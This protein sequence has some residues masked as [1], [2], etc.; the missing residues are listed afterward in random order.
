MMFNL[1]EEE[2]MIQETAHD[3]AES[4]LR[5]RAEE[6]DRKESFPRENF[7][8]LSEL[9]FMGI[10]V[11][12][13]YGGS[14]L[15]DFAL[16][17]V[18]EEINR[19]CA[20]TGVTL[21]VHNSLVC[22][23]ITQFGTEEQKKHYLPKL[24]SGELIG[25][26]VVTEP[27]TGSDAASIQTSA[28]R[29]GNHYIINGTKQWITTGSQAGAMIVFARTEKSEKL[30]NGIS[31]F[32]VEPGFKGFN[33]GKQEKKMGIRASDTCQLIFE[34]MKV[35]AKNLLFN[36]NKGYDIL[37]WGLG[38]GRIGI[39]AQAIGIGRAAFEAATEYSKVR[40]QF[41]KFICEFQAM[42]VK[43]V[44]MATKLDAARLLT[45][46]AAKLKDENMPH[47]KESSM[48]KLFASETANFCA[49]EALQIHGGYGYTK[50]YPVE[51]FFRDAK[52]T[53]IYEG[54]S[55]IQRLVI[56]KHILES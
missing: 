44:D 17:L 7:T 23:V 21:S 4:T 56:A 41:G 46:R 3:Y 53:E 20:S 22:S 42:K 19:C 45:Y 55:E 2:K 13:E 1:T 30:K 33:V 35:P 12:E 16:V 9:G 50:E 31:A 5:K 36:E 37:R 48:A 14:G 11:P 18:L 51:R 24:A 49:T 6:Y 29:A 10:C 26:Y 40:K 8:E 39:A 52:I 15:G 54:T 34:D 47:S 32:I 43:L 27:D 28:V 38:G 25:A